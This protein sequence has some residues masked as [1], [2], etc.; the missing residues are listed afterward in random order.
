MKFYSTYE[1]PKG[2]KFIIE[3]TGYMGA[4]FYVYSHRPFFDEEIQKG[5]ECSGH[6][7]DHHQDDVAMA[8]KQGIEDF[9][10]PLDSWVKVE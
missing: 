1:H 4:Y 10:V 7:E 3:D 2:L 8:Q 5:C 6:I 9:G